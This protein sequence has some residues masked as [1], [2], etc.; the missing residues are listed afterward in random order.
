M[1]AVPVILIIQ[2]PGQLDAH[3]V[4]LLAFGE[5]VAN[6]HHHQ[7]HQQRH[8]DLHVHVQAQGCTVG[9]ANAAHHR[10]HRADPEHKAH[11]PTIDVVRLGIHLEAAQNAYPVQRHNDRGQAEDGKRL[12]APVIRLARWAKVRRHPLRQLVPQNQAHQNRQEHHNSS[13]D[14][15][16]AVFLQHICH[17]PFRLLTQNSTSSS[18]EVFRV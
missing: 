8:E 7:A 10:D 18:T 11:H 4:A 9:Q 1:G 13:N 14:E 15:R 16:L 6:D 17:S 3:G 12:A 2:R 5:P